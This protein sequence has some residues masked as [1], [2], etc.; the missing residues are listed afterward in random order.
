MSKEQ[1]VE[2]RITNQPISEL[3]REIADSVKGE[4]NWKNMKILWHSVAPFVNSGYG[5]VT[6]HMTVGLSNRGIPIFCSAYWGIQ[7][8]GLL[9]WKGLYVLP[10]RKTSDDPIGLKSAAEHYKRFK[11]DLGIFHADFWAS[12]NFPKLIPNSMCYSPIDMENY[13][14]KWLRILRAY[15]W[16]AVPSLHAQAELKKSGVNST[17]LPHGVDI[18]DYYPSNQEQSRKA[19]TLEKDKFIIGI[20]AGNNDEET[21]KGWDA[22]FLAIKYFLEANPDAKNDVQVFIHTDPTNEKGR[23]LTELANQIGVSKYIIWN[24]TYTTSVLAL[25]DAA[26]NKLYNCFDVFLLLSRREGFCLPALEAQACGV[27]CILTEFSAMIER[28]DYGKCGWLIKPS[29][30]IYSPL[31]AI[32][33]ISDPFKGADALGEAYNNEAKRKMFAKRSLAYARRQTWDIAI[34]KHF[35]PLLKEIAEEIPKLTTRTEPKKIAGN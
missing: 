1:K 18:K 32:T 33:A 29:T 6:R 23:N 34:D 19:F 9:N 21:R 5:N 4:K 8:P 30:K 12:Q 7:P 11:C 25:P 10:V 35:M 26:M 17:F 15:K 14:E 16:V 28:N 22:N 27:P 13:P 3:K 2:T 24:D 20:V 31:N